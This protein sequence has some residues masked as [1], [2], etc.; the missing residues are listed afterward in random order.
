[1]TRDCC[2][3]LLGSSGGVVVNTLRRNGSEVRA[4]SRHNGFKEWISQPLFPICNTIE[5]IKILKSDLRIH[6]VDFSPSTDERNSTKLDRKQV[7]IFSRL[8]FSG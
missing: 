2:H 7:H 4:Q 5:I 8:Y 3:F 6:F 1:M